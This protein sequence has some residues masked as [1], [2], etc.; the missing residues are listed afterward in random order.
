MNRRL[1]A[2]GTSNLIGDIID[3]A[4]ALGCEP[5][6]IVTNMPEVADPR[7]KTLEQRLAKMSKPPAVIDLSAFV[8]APGEC[9][10]LGTGAETRDQLA[11]DRSGSDEC[12]FADA[13][14]RRNKRP[15]MKRES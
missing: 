1:I 13:A 10:T 9:Y 4:L 8:P 6:A 14:R 2:F 15:R 3:C 7:G 5:A 12:P 11:D